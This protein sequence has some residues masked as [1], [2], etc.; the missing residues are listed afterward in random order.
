MS[1]PYVIILAHAGYKS[2]HTEQKFG[3]ESSLDKVKHEILTKIAKYVRMMVLAY[4]GEE[5]T[6]AIIEE[7]FNGNTIPYGLE[8]KSWIA[9]A[10]VD[11][12]WRDMSPSFDEIESTISNNVSNNDDEYDYKEEDYDYGEDDGDD[13]EEE[14]DDDGE[15][16]DNDENGEEENDDDD[17]ALPE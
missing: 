4:F 11:G 10:F 3:S 15:E 1:I 6:I 8:Q 13:G 7:L 2:Q 16:D 17:E 14:D 12:E 5:Y 9:K